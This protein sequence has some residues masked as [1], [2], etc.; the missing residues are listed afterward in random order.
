MIFYLNYLI[1]SHGTL[2]VMVNMLYTSFQ[3]LLII[4]N[5]IFFSVIVNTPKCQS[6]VIFIPNIFDYTTFSAFVWDL[7]LLITC[8]QLECCHLLSHNEISVATLMIAVGSACVRIEN[9]N[10]IRML[11]N[12]INSSNDILLEILLQE[13]WSLHQYKWYK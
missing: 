5:I 11:W 2:F 3:L 4:D 9:W 10:Q 1:F 7:K 8:W 13:E 12:I 6:D